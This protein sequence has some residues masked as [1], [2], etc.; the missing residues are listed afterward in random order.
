MCPKM[1]K[2]K[3][4]NEHMC[5]L[6]ITIITNTRNLSH[7]KALSGNSSVEGLYYL[8]NR[9]EIAQN[10]VNLKDEKGVLVELDSLRDY[11]GVCF[12]TYKGDCLKL[13]DAVAKK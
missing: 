4:F 8:M 2:K 6:N 3:T 5:I 13:T 10:L 9:V 7:K 1:A 12:T 11:D